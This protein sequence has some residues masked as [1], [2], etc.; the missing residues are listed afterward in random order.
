MTQRAAS[1]RRALIP[2][3]LLAQEV[4]VFFSE[5]SDLMTFLWVGLLI[6]YHDHLILSK[7]AD[8]PTAL[9]KMLRSVLKELAVGHR[10]LGLGR[11]PQA[12]G[13]LL[14]VWL[15]GCLA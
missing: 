2:T 11:A 10:L 6:F 13:G 15:S 7:Q 8:S 9:G 14:G 1:G 5:L 4:S 3:C 12:S